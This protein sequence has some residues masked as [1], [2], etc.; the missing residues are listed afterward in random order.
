MI[1]ILI[2]SLFI[3]SGCSLQSPV[4]KAQYEASNAFSSYTKNFLSDNNLIAKNELNRAIAHSKKNANLDS[5][6]RI[7]LGECALNISVGIEDRCENYINI[8][9]LINSKDLDIYYKFITLQIQNNEIDK[10]PI[11]Y[12]D[13]TK[14][15]NNKNYTKAYNEILKMDSEV[16]K[17]LSASLIRKHL[18]K[19]LDLLC[20]SR[21]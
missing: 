15:M 6:A 2:I 21:G 19:N 12:K 17:L 11:V 5:L 18:N 9:D 14:F 3:L 1:K 4:N 7:Y 13:F 20:K 8:R 10:L 16:S